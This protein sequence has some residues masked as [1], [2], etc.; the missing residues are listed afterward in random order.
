MN[1]IGTELEVFAHARN[2]KEYVRKKIDPYLG[3]DVL[4]VGAGSQR[5]LFFHG[6]GVVGPGAVGR[7]AGSDQEPLGLDLPDGREHIA[8]AVGFLMTDPAPDE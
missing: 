4:E 8:A 1:Y 5:L 2:W 6:D 7:G 3:G